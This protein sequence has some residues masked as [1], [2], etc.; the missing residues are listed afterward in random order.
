MY[1]PVDAVIVK[2]WGRRVGALINEREGY[3]SFQY[4]PEFVKIGLAIAPL[5]MPL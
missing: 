5:M 4:D 2:L 1:T 3:T